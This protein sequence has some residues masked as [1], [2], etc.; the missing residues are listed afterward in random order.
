MLFGLCEVPGC[1]H[2]RGQPNQ[3]P[4]ANGEPHPGFKSMIGQR[5]GKLKVVARAPNQKGNACWQCRCDCGELC[6]VQ[7]IMLREVLR[8]G[9]SY[10]CL[11]CRGKTGRRATG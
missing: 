7:G 4:R 9:R 2:Y 5:V 11:K 10:G 1:V 8:Q 3:R 6:V